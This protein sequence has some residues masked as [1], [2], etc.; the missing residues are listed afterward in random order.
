MLYY[1][2]NLSDFWPVLNVTRYITF[3]TAGA[4]LTALASGCFSAV[5]HP[6]AP[7]FQ[8]GQVIRQTGRRRT[9]RRRHAHHGRC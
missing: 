5:V 2:H 7:H 3:R 1:L 4:S 8:I 9:A 6:Q